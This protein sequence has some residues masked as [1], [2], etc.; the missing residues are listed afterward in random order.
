M[1]IIT[2]NILLHKTFWII[3][4]AIRV[5]VHILRVALFFFSCNIV[6]NPSVEHFYII[7]L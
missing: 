6:R 5:K 1:E 4:C 2:E 3:V 7:Y